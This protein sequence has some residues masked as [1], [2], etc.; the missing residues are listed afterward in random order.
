VGADRWH[1]VKEIFGAAVDQ[2]P[3]ER[4]AFLDEACRNDAALRAEV[5]SLLKHHDADEFLE[6]PAA[7]LDARAG[8]PDTPEDALVGRRLGPYDITARLGEGGM[9][10]VYLARDTRL[11]RPVA[12]K[13]LAPAFT[14]DAG[15]RAKLAREARAAAAL[16]HPSIATVYALEEFDGGLYIVGE[17][18]QGE[19][20][21]EEL[22]RGPLPTERLVDTALGIA[23]ALLAAH[24]GG[25]IHRDLK[26]ENIVRTPAGG[27]KVLDFGLAR[28]SGPA[29]E[30]E[31]I[32]SQLTQGIAGTPAYMA[33]EQ[34]RG[35]AVDFRVDLFA[36][37]ALVYELAS[38]AQPF[39]AADPIAAIA[40]VLHD[41]PGKL[42]ARASVPAALES[43]VDRC[44]RKEPG[45]RYASTRD[46]V[47]D[48]E[49]VRQELSASAGR[50]PAG[51]YRFDRA[52]APATILPLRWW[53][54]HQVV[55]GLVPCLLLIALWQVQRWTPGAVGDAFFVAASAAAVAL[56]TLRLHLAFTSR[57][58]PRE[59]PAQRARSRPWIVVGEL[60]FIIVL[61]AGAGAVAGAHRAFAA[62]LAGAGIALAIASAII[63]PA[64]TRAAFGQE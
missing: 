50:W 48:L 61:L 37:G 22:A 31:A 12:I 1:R 63:E 3:G 27:V 60:L 41:E 10:V 52:A 16:S 20:L 30:G 47:A 36:F 42:S 4:A 43:I 54:V 34:L 56:A 13:A 9:G 45:E 44:L 57:F 2:P 53:Q 64:T 32:P 35:E 33:P 46:L 18:V 26:P 23:A 8:G 29:S 24:D 58:Y 38:A 17:F 28:L 62:V 25:V 39:G 51:P 49:R 21:R 11:N 6:V 14:R 15:R 59:L 7:V 55:A 40:R 19:T 5:E